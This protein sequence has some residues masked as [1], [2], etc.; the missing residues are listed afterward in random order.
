[1]K[2]IGQNLDNAKDPDNAKD[3]SLRF[4]GSFRSALYIY[5]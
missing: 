2:S 3:M 1:M 4:I 5:K